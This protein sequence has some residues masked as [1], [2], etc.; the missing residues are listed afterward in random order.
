M[1]GDTR[2]TELQLGERQSLRIPATAVVRPLL[3]SLRTVHAYSTRTYRARF[4][5][6]VAALVGGGAMLLGQQQPSSPAQEPLPTFRSS[7]EAVQLT[8]IVTDAEGNPVAGLTQDDFEI[9]EDDAPRP[10]TTF[11][12]VDIPIE[13]SERSLAESDVLSNDGPPGRTYVIAFDDIST[14]QLEGARPLLRQFI[15]K[16]FGPNDRGAVV[17]TTVATAS[18]GSGHE[19]TSNP[20]LLLEAID[21]FKGVPPRGERLRW[22]R[23]HWHWRGRRDGGPGPKPAREERHGRTCAS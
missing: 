2:S 3:V 17:A 19:F 20:R 11:S 13:R 9:F 5:A 8:V 18:P 14:R 21:R 12:A 22:N 10:I 1:R 15:E 23:Q 7:V 4:I 6:T 16:Y